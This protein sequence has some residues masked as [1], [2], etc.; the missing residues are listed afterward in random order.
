MDWMEQERSAASPSPPP[1]RPASGTTIA[2]TS[3][4]RPATS[5]SPSKWS[6][7]CACSTAAWSCSTP[8]PASSRSRRRCGARPT[9]YN[10]PR[11][12]LRQQDGPH[13]RRLLALR[14]HAQRAPGRQR[15]CRSRCRS[16]LESNF[17]GIIDLIDMKAIIYTDDTGTDPHRG[18][19][20]GR[21]AGRGASSTATRMV[22]KIA[23]T[24]EE[25]TDALPRGRA[26]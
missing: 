11:I 20:P 13:R 2:S 25:L 14:R 5:T 9:S 22:E 18:R 4:T 7:R 3:S 23:E 6:A 16:A 12:V 10:V 19:D 8:W 17:Q 26:I 1:R 21:D 24:D 15:R